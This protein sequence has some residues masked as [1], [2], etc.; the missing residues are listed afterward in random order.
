MK[1]FHSVERVSVILQSTHLFIRVTVILDD[2]NPGQHVFPSIRLEQILTVG[3]C[4]SQNILAS[5]FAIGDVNQTGLDADSQRFLIRWWRSVRHS[6]LPVFVQGDCVTLQNSIHLLP[7]PHPATDTLH[8][9][10]IWIMKNIRTA[11]MEVVHWTIQCAIIP[12][13]SRW[14][15]A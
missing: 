15:V 14:W 8:G 5:C 10:Q 4:E 3:G 7:R 2:T 13:F 12:Y 1:T 11:D 6:I 9:K